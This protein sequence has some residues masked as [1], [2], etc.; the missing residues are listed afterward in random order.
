VADHTR[1]CTLVRMIFIRCVHR[2]FITVDKS[3]KVLFSKI[4][5]H[6]CLK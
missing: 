1:L 6:R 5:I 2:L 3:N 4:E